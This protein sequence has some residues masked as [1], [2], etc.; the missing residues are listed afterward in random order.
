ME[1]DS[2][3]TG[4]TLAATAELDLVEALRLGDEAA[5]AALVDR[6]QAA[7]LHTA[8]AVVATRAV[9]EEVVQE[10][11]LGVLGGIRRFEGRSSLKTWILRIVINLAKRRAKLEARS[12]SFSS[13]SGIESDPEPAV[14]PS[15][16]QRMDGSLPRHWVSFPH[17]WVGI[18]EARLLSKETMDHVRKSIETL[19]PLQRKVIT[20]RDIVGWSSSEVCNAMAISETN[21]RVLL[22]RA[23][24]K[25]RTVLEEYLQQ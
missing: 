15:R 24:S 6:Y 17:S 7:M 16:F 2:G 4:S 8:L 18:P 20:L 25:I 21:Q 10:A 11:W 1:L 23:R 22:H 19:P 13:L 9:A 14:D 3:T 5:F 12:L